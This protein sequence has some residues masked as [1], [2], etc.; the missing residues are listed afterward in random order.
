MEV[1][2]IKIQILP[3]AYD[4]NISVFSQF[5][6]HFPKSRTPLVNWRST[7]LSCQQEKIITMLITS[8]FGINN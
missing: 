6:P 5:I 7:L 8:C 4:S 2:L 3:D 1:N